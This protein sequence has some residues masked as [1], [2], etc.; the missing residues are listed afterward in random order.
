LV[1]V[2]AR[3]EA[4]AKGF[5]DA[6]LLNCAG[7]VVEATGANLFWIQNGAVGTP[8]LSSGALAGVT[9]AVVLELCATLG[10]RC[11]ERSRSVEALVRTDALFLTQ[12]VWGI[13][14]VRSI[15]GVPVGASPVVP[16]LQAAYQELIR[17]ET[18]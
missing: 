13:V 6:I 4:E 11:A 2:L 7:E 3:A 9:R 15:E 8:P 5:D 10:I 16:Q 18:A 17:A 1:H 12:T 14:P